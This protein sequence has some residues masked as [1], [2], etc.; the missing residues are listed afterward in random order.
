MA[1]WIAKDELVYQVLGA[2]TSG[3]WKEHRPTFEATAETFRELS[4]DELEEVRENRLRLV[5]ARKG[6]TLT[7]VAKRSDS[8]W[9]APRM[10]VANAM[11]TQTKLAG[12]ESI[13]VSK[14]ERYQ[15]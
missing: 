7:Q 1:V 12:G 10:G 13:K 2:T 11:K 9:S 14:R 4:R 15:Q 6:E 3:R 8:E 5:A